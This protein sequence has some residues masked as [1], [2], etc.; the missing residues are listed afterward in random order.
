[1]KVILA[2]TPKN[3]L[4]EPSAKVTDFDALPALVEGM[5]ETM[6]DHPGISAPQ[7]GKNLRVFVVNKSVTRRKDHLVVVNPKV[8]PQGGQVTEAEACLSLPDQT[9]EITRKK[10]CKIKCQDMQ[11]NWRTFKVKG[12]TARV[13]QHE[14][15]HLYGILIDDEHHR[16]TTEIS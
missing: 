12:F 2:E 4:R 1:M 15:D 7:V 13:I 9:F 6:G 5:I 11:G 8:T 10:R 3:H 16:N 14:N